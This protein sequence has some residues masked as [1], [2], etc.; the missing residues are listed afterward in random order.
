MRTLS[1]PKTT[2]NYGCIKCPII[3]PSKEIFDMVIDKFEIPTPHLKIVIVNK[4]YKSLRDHF[5]EI[6][7]W[8]YQSNMMKSYYHAED[9]EGKECTKLLKMLSSLRDI[10]PQELHIFTEVISAFKRVIDTCF[11]KDS[12]VGYKNSI[13]NF[14]TKWCELFDTFGVS[15]TNK[16]HIIMKHITQKIERIGTSLY[17][18]NE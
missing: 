17:N 10:L 7:E 9:F 18:G 12:Q 5:S 11:G 16:A 8:S 1:D 13:S 14:E 15:I 2:I 6:D 4:I 3:Y